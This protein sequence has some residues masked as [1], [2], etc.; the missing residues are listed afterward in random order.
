[1]ILTYSTAYGRTLS[2]APKNESIG[3]KKIDATI[4][5]IA[6]TDNIIVIALPA[7]YIAFFLFPAPI[8]RLKPEAPPMPKTRAVATQMVVNGNEIFV[9]AFVLPMKSWSTIL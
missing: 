6:P 9:A 1:M 2:V 7:K 5:T 4:V 3:L 8:F